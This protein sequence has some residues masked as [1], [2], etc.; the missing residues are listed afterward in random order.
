MMK[1]V[2]VLVLTVGLVL[3]VE[4]F[5]ISSAE[6]MGDGKEETRPAKEGTTVTIRCSLSM[7]SGEE[8][9]VCLWTH[10]L[11]GQFDQYN[12]EKNIQCQ[13]LPN[14]QGQTCL[15][16][17][18]SH[19]LDSAASKIKMDVSAQH[20]GIVITDVNANY[21]DGTW[22]C[23]VF[24]A[25]TTQYSNVE[26]FVTNK[27]TVRMIQPDAWAQNPEMIKYDLDQSRPEIRA[28][29][30]GYGGSPQPTFKWYVNDD[31]RQINKNDYTANPIRVGQDPVYGNYVEESITFSPSYEKLC[32]EY[33]LGNVCR[34]DVFTFNLICKSDQGSYYMTESVDSSTKALVEVRNGSQFLTASIFLLISSFLASKFF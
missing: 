4:A 2:L 11:T 10:K 12:R 21:H 3:N 23:S 22:D 5:S 17:G 31:R 28:T 19:D 18:G 6:V 29:C 8:W 13:A 7:Q 20:C 32:G 24:A 26:L 33:G 25:G 27:T 1:F 14:S 15:N 9:S 16:S 30:R 34:P